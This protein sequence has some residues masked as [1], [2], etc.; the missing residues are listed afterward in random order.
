[1]SLS[2]R[3]R[4][5]LVGILCLPVFMA[6]GQVGGKYYT[7]YDVLVNTVFSIELPNGS[8]SFQQP[9]H[10]IAWKTSNPVVIYYQPD[11]GYIGKDSLYV[12]GLMFPNNFLAKGLAF[13]VKPSIV[14]ARNDYAYV[15]V[16][17]SNLDLPVLANDSTSMGLGHLKVTHVSVVNNGT[18]TLSAGGDTIHFTPDAN[19]VGLTH[20]IYT[21]CDTNNI[22][23]QGMATI[24]VTDFNPPAT[25]TSYYI[26]NENKSIVVTL[27]DI[28]FS[29]LDA[30]ARGQLTQLADFVFEYSPD[31]NY[32]GM[33]S[34]N[35][36]I[37][38]PYSTASVYVEVLDAPAPNSFAIEDFAY[39]SPLVD[40]I[41]IDV[42]ANDVGV[43]V[44][45]KSTLKIYT[46]PNKG[47]A[48]VEKNGNTATGIIWYYPNTNAKGVDKFTYEI[49]NVFGKRE[50][51]DVYVIISD[52]KP[53]S[54]TY[55][56][57][58]PKNTPLV[59]NYQIPITSYSF[60]I[61]TPPNS[62]HGTLV[63]YPGDTAITFGNQ[64][65]HGYN[66]L[67]FEP[68]EEFV[69]EDSSD[70]VEFEV[71]YCVGSTCPTIKIFLTVQDMQSSNPFC[72][73]NPCVWA[74]DADN[75]GIV[76]IRDVLCIGMAMGEDGNV[77]SGGSTAW[78]GQ[79]S[80]QWEQNA[81]PVNLKYIDTDGNGIV[82]NADTA[83]IRTHYWKTHSIVP[84]ETPVAKS[85][86]SVNILT[87]LPVNLGD[88]VELEVEVG[89]INNPML[90]MYGFAY[91][92]I[93]NPKYLTNVH[94]S[95]NVGVP[96]ST[97]AIGSYNHSWFASNSPMLNMLVQPHN[98]RLDFAMSRTNGLTASGYGGVGHITFIIT[99]DFNGIRG[100]EDPSIRVDLAHAYAMNSAGQYVRLNDVAIDIPVILEERNA[101]LTPD[102][103][104]AFPNPTSHLL[105]LHMNGGYEI[106]EVGLYSML[107]QRVLYTSNL[108]DRNHRMDVYG[109]PAGTYI[110]RV[111]TDKGPVSKKVII[112][113]E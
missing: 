72:I 14:V 7:N 81:G 64:T 23:D 36:K 13:N 12:A 71:K 75:N 107:G 2:L 4:T 26:T 68:E 90:D 33:D 49:K 101:P 69:T 57:T 51:A 94:D 102:M 5:L 37:D 11:A 58:T 47:T 30:P 98:G 32:V 97:I 18:T 21:V 100:S 87:P 56:L 91:S 40:S 79:H 28:G 105:N 59:I 109:V 15:G 95:V 17:A 25:D 99:E 41:D 6:F 45:N 60:T 96:D 53:H 106:Q 62:N 39:I 76:D 43:N 110:V 44:L 74:G 9:A 24:R 93:F 34:F 65:I 63:Y 20:L 22:C 83:A 16:N 19:Y 92:F 42:L 46:P 38:S 113:R 67:V 85:P 1:M 82:S 35:F 29:V 61:E 88:M 111:M 86:V 48:V 112:V 77:R 52:Y 70:I 104:I 54:F 55:D 31:P 27:P 89:N 73:G 84:K 8:Y 10:G 66:M 80:T 78:Y 50:F 3:L 103:L 108:S